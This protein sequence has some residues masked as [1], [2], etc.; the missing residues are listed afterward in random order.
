MADK[1]ISEKDLHDDFLTAM[2]RSDQPKVVPEGFMNDVMKRLGPLPSSSRIK[3]YSPP[4]WLKWG[5]P[6][7]I[8]SLLPVLL[9]WGAAKEPAAPY[10]GLSILAESFKAIN[11]WFSGINIQIDFPN[12]EFSETIV[13]VLAG[14]MILIWSFLLLAGFLEKKVRQ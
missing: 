14:G 8:F 4:I 3:A 1:M 12:L 6:G 9:I 5:V 2:I 11:S 13:W 7:T 10:Q